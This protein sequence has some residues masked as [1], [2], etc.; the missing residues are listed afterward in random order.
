MN[1]RN[2]CFIVVVL[3]YLLLGIP[4]V[5]FCEEPNIPVYDPNDPNNWFPSLTDAKLKLWLSAYDLKQQ[6]KKEGEP[7]LQWVDRTSFG[8]IFSPREGM[9][10]EPHYR[11]IQINGKLRP[12]VHF[13]S[14][15]NA[16]DPGNRDRLWQANNKGAD[17]PL[18]SGPGEALTVIAVWANNDIGGTFSATDQSIITF[19]GTNTAPW[20]LGQA[21]GSQQSYGIYFVSGGT[22]YPSNGPVWPGGTL[23][24]ALMQISDTDILNFFQDMDGDM[25]VALAPVNT[26]NTL[27]GRQGPAI[28]PETEGAG[29][30][31]HDQDVQGEL[32]CFTGY[33]CEIIVYGRALSAQEWTDVQA[34]LTD[35]YFR[36]PLQPNAADANLRLWMSAYDL[37]DQGMEPGDPVVEWVDKSSYGT[38][39][40]PRQT[41][42]FAG[43]EIP[44]YAEVLIN[45]VDIPCPAIW[46]DLAEDGSTDRLWQTTN[47]TNNPL[48]I[49]N[50]EDLTV[51]AVWANYILEGG[52]SSYDTIIAMR[53]TSSCPWYFG[54]GAGG[55]L[56]DGI[57]YVTY[58]GQVQWTCGGPIWQPAVFGVGMMQISAA[59]VLN[60]YQ[61][62]DGD[63]LVALQQTNTK[64]ASVAVRNGPSIAPEGAGIACH[65]QDCCGGQNSPGEGFS[66][67]I[68]EILVYKKVLSA[69][70]LD[71]IQQYL[72]EKY[73]SSRG[74][75]CT[76][77]PE[78]DFNKDC[79]VDLQDFAQFSQGWLECNIEP[80]SMCP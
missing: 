10:E 4:A 33:I 56:S 18:N 69:A 54:Q 29:I 68:S 55:R 39:F 23:G 3:M 79:Y 62:Y 37:Q 74:S 61:D 36:E 2:M 17:N 80:Q 44:E 76:Q 5:S 30:G 43:E 66:G 70:E 7:V 46:F 1:T 25:T 73:F 6:G 52:G 35:K 21:A 42:P 27:V 57:Y 63:S 64:D 28:S 75:Y 14:S 22:K 50:G 65:D 38:V 60:F 11:Q 77:Y 32:E 58:A 19:R 45:S 72:S 41:I 16:L 15:G 47:K 12:A 78:A 13:E 31:C 24:V 67:Y 20:M 8:T 40:A 71:D 49:G 34:Y 26:Q 51:I 48:A 53:G 59:N 9:M